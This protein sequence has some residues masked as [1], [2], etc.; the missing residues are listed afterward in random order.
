[1]VRF[2]AA[3]IREDSLITN[4]IPNRD[5]GGA[6]VALQPDGKMVAGGFTVDASGSFWNL[7]VARFVP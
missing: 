5:A 6:H 3:G 2:S 1:M 7:A 4:F